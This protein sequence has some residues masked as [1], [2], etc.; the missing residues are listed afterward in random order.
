MNGRAERPGPTGA[1][2][3]ES[4]VSDQHDAAPDAATDMAGALEAAE[5]KAAENWDRYLRA[6]AEIE[7]IRKR[8]SR[9]VVHVR[10]LLFVLDINTNRCSSSDSNNHQIF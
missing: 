3:N 2:E 6:A 10:D 9:E 8:A 1:D 5:A 7:N 4:D